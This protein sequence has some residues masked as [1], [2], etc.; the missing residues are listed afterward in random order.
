MKPSKAKSVVQVL[1]ALLIVA[2][3]IVLFRII[4]I[5]V[6]ID[7]LQSYLASMGIAGA[8]IY[9]GIYI[10]AT[11]LLIPGSAL[12]LLAGVLYGPVEGTM[13]VSVGATIGSVV[14]YLLGRYAFRASVERATKSNPKFAA[15]DRAIG[16][17]GTKILALLRLSPVVP[18]SLSN[19]FFGL[20]SIRFW[21]YTLVSWIF[22]LPGTL[23]YVY[24]GYTASQA[25]GSGNSSGLL[26]W[27]LVILGLVLIAVVTVYITRVAKKAL[28]SQE[29]VADVSK[30]ATNIAPMAGSSW[31]RPAI[32][33]IVAV[34]MLALTGFAWGKRDALS[35]IFGPPPVKLA[36]KFKSNPK[37]PQF[38]NS[39]FNKVVSTYV[40]KGGW[41]D[42][43]G[44]AAHPQNLDAYIA[45]VAKAPFGELGRDNKLALLINA[46]NAFTLRLILDHYPNIRSIRD[47]PA[48]KRWDWVHWSIGG[49]LYSLDQIELMLRSDFGDPRVH[50]AI[51]CASIGC[52]ELA[53]QAYEP[54]TIEA[55]LQRQAMAINNN[56]RW[57]RLSK[58]GHT[59][60][61]TE[62][63]SWYGGD[64]D[65]AAGS[66]LKFVARFNKLVATELAKGD[67]PTISYKPYSWRLDSIA[68]KHLVAM[69]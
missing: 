3:L 25:A 20:T 39:L 19:Y 54:A 26:H 43:V 6:G 12:T 57:V 5:G 4:P 58:S 62:I 30:G 63:Y 2:C 69:N 9:I 14:A 64:F 49:K 44:L 28:A 45:K 18:F 59:L 21:P 17:N 40:H 33:A 29:G 56:P 61:L 8:F 68:N 35:G 47:I 23:L 55:Q 53:R 24:L 7:K 46:Y 36:N 16:K 15:I 42:Y 1:S 38:N 41:V 32:M 31:K 51:N 34:V 52:P 60:H 65:Q 27:V 50:F 10:V 13:V 66:V 22:T 11:V 37:G 48:A 67:P